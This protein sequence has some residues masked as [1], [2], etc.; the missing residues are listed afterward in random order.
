MDTG[1]DEKH[2]HPN[3]RLRDPGVTSQ[4]AE[5]KVLKKEHAETT[6][7][8]RP[9]LAV[10]AQSAGA[11]LGDLTCFAIQ[12]ACALSP[13]PSPSEA[14]VLSTRWRPRIVG[15]IRR[16]PP[17]WYRWPRAARPP[18]RNTPRG[19]AVTSDTADLR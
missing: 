14:E 11:S 15:R 2:E 4:I 1:V 19:Y 18:P 7:R 12:D 9:L 13:R 3:L 6:A 16:P 5:P 10:A 8:N 17:V